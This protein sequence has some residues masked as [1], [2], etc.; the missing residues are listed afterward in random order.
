MDHSPP[1]IRPDGTAASL[2]T[3]Y[4][5]PAVRRRI[6]EFL[7]G[8]SHG[9]ATAH[10]IAGDDTRASLRHPE[11]VSSLWDFLDAQREVSRSLWD[12]GSLVVHL[13]V[14]YVNF[15]DPAEA[16]RNPERIFELQRP[17]VEATLHLLGG[18]GIEPLHVLSGRG[19]HF[20]WSV[21][22]GSPA[23][24]RLAALGHGPASIWRINAAPHRP[25]AEGVPPEM[26]AAFAGLGLLMEFLAHRIQKTA[27]PMSAIPIE[28]TAVEVG[29]RFRDRE[30]VSLDISEYGDPLH[31]RTLRVPFS[32]YHKPAQLGWLSDGDGQAPLAPL[33]FLPLGRISVSEALKIRHDGARVAALA[34]QVSTAIPAQ[35]DGTA[36]LV[37]DY[38][39]SPLAQFHAWFYSQEQ[40]GAEAWPETYDRTALDVLPMCARAMLETPNDLLLHPSSMRLLT[41]IL[42]ALG[43]HPR[44]IAGLICSRF[45]RDYDWRDQWTECDPATRADFYTRVFAG[46]FAVGNDDLTDLNCQSAKEQQICGVAECGFN[47]QTFQHSALARR[48]Y[49]QLAHRPFHRLFPSQP[50]S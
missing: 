10:F 48:T 20:V 41:R 35:A 5:D 46:L 2:A 34:A 18:Y 33:C 27:A 19:H 47:L 22:K 13:D 36:R 14:E 40:H 32:L 24:A 29:P 8:D 28:L 42:L 31:T 50:H 37:D 23:F 38:L 11:P 30:M 15:D 3:L 26:G 49:D 17:A 9:T 16:C 39:A 4:A 12:R 25:H 45:A 7:G 6:V 44:H 43:W 1:K 21:P